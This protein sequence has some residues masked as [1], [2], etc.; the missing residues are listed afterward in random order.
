MNALRAA[1]IP[2]AL[3]AGPAAAQQVDREKLRALLRL[4]MFEMSVG[5]K[6]S[7]SGLVGEVKPKDRRKEIKQVEGMLTGEPRDAERHESLGDLYA[8]TGDHDRAGEAYR[9][10]IELYRQLLTSDPKNGLHLAGL[11]AC[12]DEIEEHDQAEGTLLRAVDAAP[13]E[14]KAWLKLGRCLA[15]KSGRALHAP[16]GDW[17][18]FGPDGLILVHLD[19][20]P[21]PEDIENA[22][23]LL[24]EAKAAFDRAVT[25]APRDP[26]PYSE[27]ARFLARV[28]QVFD[29]ALRTLAGEAAHV[30]CCPPGVVPDLEQA[31][32][33]DPGDFETIAQAAYARVLSAFLEAH[34][35]P[36]QDCWEFLSGETRKAI[37]ESMDRLRQYSEKSSNPEV[38]GALEILSMLQFTFVKDRSVAE[39]TARRAVALDPSREKAWGTLTGVL[40]IGERHEEL[41]AATRERFKHQDTAEVRYLLA[42][43]YERLDDWK[44]AELTLKGILLTEPNHFH[45]NLGLA[46]LYLKRPD[47]EDAVRRAGELIDVAVKGMGDS[48]SAGQWKDCMLITGV[49]A[50]LTGEVDIAEKRIRNL[51]AFDPENEDAKEALTA[52][53][54]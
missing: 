4:P 31:A 45:A 27:R 54:K 50:A 20:R 14:W 40:I 52:L 53:G 12:L 18:S 13:G 28:H 42:K 24:G 8:R 51:L 2:I 38:A 23:R 6:F 5:F 35:Q 33:L 21:P 47:D 19:P 16:E 29:G 36:G 7:S 25:A 49:F 41:V 15:S 22:R 46:A 30:T 39:A 17:C 1:W 26:R 11:G 10:A 48:Y 43:G 32:R 3:L 37:E 34:K 44:Q 9:R